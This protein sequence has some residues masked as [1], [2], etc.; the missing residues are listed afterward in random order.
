VSLLQ[1]VHDLLL[2]GLA[3]NE[4]TDTTSSLL[5]FLGQQGLRISKRKLQ[6][7]KQEVKYL[8][9]LISKGKHRLGS[10]C[11]EGITGMPLPEIK[12]ELWKFWGLAG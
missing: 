12:R 4:V 9:Y 7:V 10:Q 2:S 5:N 8:E 3:K 1:Y 6:F 11:V